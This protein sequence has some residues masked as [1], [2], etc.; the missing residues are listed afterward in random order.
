LSQQNDNL[1]YMMID[2]QKNPEPVFVNVIN[3]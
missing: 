2:I 3:S 1:K